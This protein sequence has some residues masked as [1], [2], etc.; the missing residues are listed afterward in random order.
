MTLGNMAFRR[1]AL[2]TEFVG[3]TRLFSAKYPSD[4]YDGWLGADS[5]VMPIDVLKPLLAKAVPDPPISSMGCCVLS[6]PEPDGVYLITADPAGFGGSGD[7]SALTVWD[8]LNRREV[9][10]WEDREDPGR[11]AQRL[12]NIQRIYN[13]A[14]LAVESNAMA[15]IAVLKDQNNR[16]LLWT[17]RTHPGWYATSKRLQ[18]AEARLV[19]LL[20]EGDIEILSKG[21]LHQLVNYD[22][23]RKKRVKGLDGT[24]HHYDRARTAVMAA[25]IL[26]RRRFTQANIEDNTFDRVSGQ[27]TISDLDSLRSGKAKQAKS[28]FKPPPRDWM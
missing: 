19:Q 24:T 25:D 16:N 7:K 5:P 11:F 26:S 1:Q 18:E 23:S 15:C 17:S 9:A 13:N 20:R 4:P 12:V 22:G 3:D 27:L 8:A 28:L 14:L 6:K 21:M 2:N 10:F